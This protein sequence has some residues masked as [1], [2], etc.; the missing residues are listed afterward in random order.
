MSVGTLGRADVVVCGGALETS[1]EDDRPP[2]KFSN[3]RIG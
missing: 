3:S 1:V 2:N